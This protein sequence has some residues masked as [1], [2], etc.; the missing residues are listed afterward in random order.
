[1]PSQLVAP[2]PPHKNRHSIG[3][4]LIYVLAGCVA[5]LAV[6][7]LI[8]LA[9][10]PQE[11]DI[12]MLA[13]TGTIIL[14][15]TTNTATSTATATATTTHTPT[16][17]CTPSPTSTPLPTH[18]PL[19][20]ST[21]TATPL[22]P[23]T[24]TPLPTYTPLPPAATSA[25]LSVAESI[26]VSNG[27]WGERELLFR[28][29]GD[30][31]NGER[32]Y[33]TGTDGHRYLVKMGFLSSVEAAATIQEY[34]SLAGRGSANWGMVVLVRKQIDDWYLCAS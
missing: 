10:T 33:I 17:T 32:F 3:T 14:P 30:T 13:A 29:E 21:G 18:T 12:A 15:T 5:L 11:P 7:Q 31:E 9:R 28:Y 25:P 23:P 8:A 20:T 2:P 1:M 34:W 27:T 24:T 4:R 26:K 16:T 19:P 6:G 22:P